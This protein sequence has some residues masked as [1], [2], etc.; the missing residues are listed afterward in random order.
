[1]ITSVFI[2]ITVINNFNT[3]PYCG[4]FFTKRISATELQ[5]CQLQ[6]TTYLLNFGEVAFETVY[7]DIQKAFDKVIHHVVIQK[8]SRQIVSMVSQVI[9]VVLL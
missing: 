5:R 8:L 7:T 4:A 1:M 2:L 3:P 6:T 9:I